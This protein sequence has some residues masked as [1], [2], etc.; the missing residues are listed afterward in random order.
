[1]E[2]LFITITCAAD[3]LLGVRAERATPGDGAP[4]TQVAYAQIELPEA[5]LIGDLLRQVREG[6]G[7]GAP[8]R[9][10][11][12]LGGLL[13]AGEVGALLRGATDESGSPL[14]ALAVDDALAGWPWELARDPDG[15]HRP[16]LDGAGLIRIAGRPWS[17]RDIPPRGVLAVPRLSGQP[18]VDAL[19]ASTRGLSRKLQIDVF[20]ADP[21][22]GP[23]LRRLLADG[24]AVVHIEGVGESDRVLL[25]DGPVPFD[26]LGITSKCWLT[27]LGGTEISTEAARQLREAG[28]ALVIGH[29]LELRPHQ[30]AAIDREL[31]RGLAARR[32][33]VEALARVRRT[34]ARIEGEDSAAW[35]APVLWSAPGE[36]PSALESF[37]PRVMKAPTEVGLGPAMGPAVQIRLPYPD[38][39]GP[40]GHAIS[41]AVFVRDT[42]RRLQAG[43]ST[44]PDLSARSTM[45][46]ALAGDTSAPTDP[47]LSAAE[48]PARLADALIAGIGHADRPLRRPDDWPDRLARV[49][50]QAAVAEQ[51][52]HEAAHALLVSPVVHLSGGPDNL[53]R[54]LGEELFGYH[55]QQVTAERTGPILGG[56]RRHADGRVYGAG[57][58]YQT[59]ARNWRRDQLDPLRPDQPDPTVRMPVIA[60]RAGNRGYAL[61]PGVWLV[62]H[63]GGA[64]EAGALRALLRATRSGVLEGLTADGQPYRLRVP[65]DFRVILTGAIAGLDAPSI[66]VGPSGDVSVQ[67]ARWLAEAQ[68]Q[69][70]A[71]DDEAAAVGR[72]ALA[73]RLGLIAPA[74]RWVMADRSDGAPLPGGPVL[75]YAIER[76]TTDERLDEALR[77]FIGG[78]LRALPAPRQA[79]A[80]AALTGEREALFRAMAHAARQGDVTPALALAESLGRAD[81]AGLAGDPEKLAARLPDWQGTARLELPAGG[82]S[83]ADWLAG[84]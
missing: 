78:R 5:E 58:L 73:R 50:E 49:A 17:G 29:Q 80:I 15:G 22:T 19:S 47:G 12:L 25:D 67:C 44:D 31:Y 39:P 33:P 40:S 8:A 74:L 21:A 53:A 69:V 18:R 3:D 79:I 14:V 38:L 35:A 56:P 10:G 26:R 59:V 62:V 48:R 68:H 30:S 20:P 43:D 55:L 60:P 41:A 82:S 6:H 45:L 52:V 28:S 27:V 37:P 72:R 42:M 84:R 34:L 11:R 66:A 54:L 16:A 65:S 77:L 51:A 1:M 83:L 63:D 75:A 4:Q 24:A 9:L 71:A 23:G 36:P 81:A 32:G 76:G 2:P 64:L 46:R 13:Y 70:G 7:A 57:W 61:R